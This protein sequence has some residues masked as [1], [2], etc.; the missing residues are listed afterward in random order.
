ML[1]DPIFKTNIL[2]TDDPYIRFYA[3]TAIVIDGIK[4]GT[5]CVLSLQ[6]KFNFGIKQMEMLMDI[7]SILSNPKCVLKEN[8]RS[9][10]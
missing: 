3:G 8:L 6:S 2:A 10:L 7:A 1:Q 9:S 5:I 4:I